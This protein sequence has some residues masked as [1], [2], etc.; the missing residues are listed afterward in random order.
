MILSWTRAD[1]DL[2]PIP[3]LRRE[4]VKSIKWLLQPVHGQLGHCNDSE[5]IILSLSI[6]K[7]L[8]IEITF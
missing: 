2:V 3:P 7:N 6:I 8:V 5:N 4:S 1:N